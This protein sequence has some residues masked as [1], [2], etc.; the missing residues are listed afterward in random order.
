[1]EEFEESSRLE[2]E[3]NEFESNSDVWNRE[4]K[5]EAWNWECRS[6]IHVRYLKS[7]LEEFEPS[8]KLGIG[9][10]GVRVTFRCLESGMVAFNPSSRLGIGNVRVRA[11]FRRLESE[12]EEFVPSSM[13]GIGN[14]GVRDKFEVWNRK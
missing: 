3:M 10:G 7:E 11:K 1:M 6:S 8:S 5:F 2:S 4:W 14:G 12:M 9:N 13:L